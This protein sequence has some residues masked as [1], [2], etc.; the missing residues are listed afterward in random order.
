MSFSD[1]FSIPNIITIMRMVGACALCFTETLSQEF[2]IIYTFCG[3]T[4]VLDGAAA[5]LL[6]QTSERGAALDSVADMLFYSIMAVKIFPIL[7]ESL[8][9]ILWVS[10]A[11]IIV[12]RFISYFIAAKKYH[13]FASL[14][15]WLNKATGFIVFLM[16]YLLIQLSAN[17][18][19]AVLAVVSAAATLEELFIHITTEEYNPEKKSIIKRLQRL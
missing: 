1:F 17:I 15:T 7:M 13:R 11:V 16:P 19:C 18:I 2:Y 5:R 12:I 14:H 4:D 10:A 6:K 8:S 3:I 9:I